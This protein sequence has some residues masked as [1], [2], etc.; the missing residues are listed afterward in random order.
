MGG[1]D[2]DAE[3]PVDG[4]V[5]TGPRSGA[6]G[7]VEGGKSGGPGLYMIE[8]SGLYW[9]GSLGTSW[10]DKCCINICVVIRVITALPLE[11]GDRPPKLSWKSS[12]CRQETFHSWME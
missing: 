8:P 1:W 3:L 2:S 11:K 9:V 7:K 5:G 4:E 12:I 6:G 10:N